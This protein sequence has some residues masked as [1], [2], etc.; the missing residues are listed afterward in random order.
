[1]G[2]NIGVS[3]AKGEYI[4][5]LDNDTTVTPDFLQPLI[6]I[7]EKDKSIGIIQP[8]IR[9]MIHKEL[10]DSVGSYMTESG[11]LYHFGYMKPYKMEIYTK[12]LFAYSIKGACFLIAKKDYLKLGGLDKM[13]L[14]YVEETD[15]CHR[16]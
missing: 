12:P 8:Q 16:M 1:M 7:M 4:L 13:F 15:L 14:S 2:K 3:E 11:I 9:S 10:L 5:A 6:E